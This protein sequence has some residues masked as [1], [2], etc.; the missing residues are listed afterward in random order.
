[1]G[2]LYIVLHCQSCYNKSGIFTGRADVK[3]TAV[4]HDHAE[5]ISEELK[6]ISIDKAYSS[7]LQ[8]TRQTLA[9]ILKYHP[10]TKKSAIKSIQRA[11]RPGLRKYTGKSSLPRVLNGLG[12]AVISTSLPLS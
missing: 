8:R 4:G 6:D 11:S 3:L 1:M 10:E 2:M 7:S 5:S 9:H 12:I